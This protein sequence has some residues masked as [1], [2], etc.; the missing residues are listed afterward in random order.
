MKKH[1]I[2]ISDMMDQMECIPLALKE[3]NTISAGHIRKKTLEKVHNSSLEARYKRK[4]PRTGIVAA[5]LLLCL[6]MTVAAGQ[7]LEWDGFIRMDDLNPREKEALIKEISD[8]PACSMATDESDGSVLFP[9]NGNEIT[10]LSAPE[11]AEYETAGREA[12]EQAV[13]ESTS[14]IHVSALPCL[15]SGIT[16]MEADAQGRFS[17]FLAGNGHM[18]LLHPVGEDGFLLAKGDTITI[19][20]DADCE[21]LL[22]FRAYQGGEPVSEALMLASRHCYHYTA[23]EDGIY[24]FSILHC[25]SDPVSFTDCSIT[26]R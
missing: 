22:E 4:I 21:C 10:S 2:K 24:Q 5:A 25:S 9:N 15:P 19:T 14:L 7:I 11:A 26:I 13:L 18:I 20:M 3:Y 23:V 6:S 17:D 16:E 8:A 12:A 1:R